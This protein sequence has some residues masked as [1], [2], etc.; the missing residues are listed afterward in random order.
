MLEVT[1]AHR[2]LET[3]FGYKE[4]RPGQLEV[5]TSLAETGRA[6]AVF[7]TGGGKSIC[8]QLPALTYPGVTLV[9]SPL[10]ALMKDQ[11][12]YLNS[13]GVAAA[14]LDSSLSL[15]EYRQT[16]DR[17]VSGELKLVYVAP[18]RFNN[19]RFMALVRKTKVSLFA[20]DE[21][22]C[23]SEW[24]HNFRPDYLKLA[25][26]AREIKAER[27]L[28]LTATASPEVVR[29]ICKG[30]DILPECAVVTGFYRNN[31]FMCLTPVPPGDKNALLIKRLQLRKPGSTIVYC[32][33]QKTAERTS[34]EL[35]SAGFEARHYHAGMEPE[36]RARVQEW[37]MEAPAG[38]VVATIAFGMGID[39]AAVRYVYHYNL[40]SSLEAYSQEIGRAGRDGERATVEL[41]ACREDAATIEN[42]AY[43]DTPTREAIRA[44]CGTVLLNKEEFSV[45][46]YQL[47]SQLDIR[48]VVLRTLFAYVELDGHLRQG[49]P[50]YSTYTVS[51]KTSEADAIAAFTGEPAQF[52]ADVLRSGK[53]CV[54]KGAP[55][56]VIDP[57]A[58]AVA[59]GQPR[60]R[61]VKALEVI[62]DRGFVELA[63]SDLRQ[64]Y[65]PT[66]AEKV[67]IERIADR[68]VE[69]F[70]RREA[71][72]VAGPQRVLDL[73]EHD[74]C[75]T[76]A[77]VAHFGEIRPEKCG[78][79]SWCLN[80]KSPGLPPV[81]RLSPLPD[82]LE[83][84]AVEALQSANPGAL[85][86]PRQLARFLCGLTS[87]ALTRARLSRH[88][89]FGVWEHRRF[90]EVLEWCEKIS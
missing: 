74:G 35:R 24:G 34:E 58:V 9:V 18:E 54:R 28:A 75:Q 78:H 22:H 12:T 59:L 37:W 42:F 68:L 23:I 48:M 1:E 88:A 11:I 25:D 73:V 67:D 87:P 90:H 6:L 2:L 55:A 43:G 39:K 60:K 79:C 81:R 83:V 3:T 31:L 10:I 16:A 40:P 63:A 82:T 26:I 46:L 89:M 85:G 65:Q 61:V 30:F 32:T 76:N 29:D 71:Q 5:I 4:F 66:T 45:D 14:R 72:A 80:G 21:A 52:L 69:R 33:L 50:Y 17:M 49:T 57:D 53:S 47:S 13:R 41:F 8:Y 38:I 70:E 44:F 86:H 36:E 56:R 15:D 7:P 51:I 77:L 20:V 62:A 64:R 27:V 19:E 84:S